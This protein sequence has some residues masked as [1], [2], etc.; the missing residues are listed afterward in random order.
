MIGEGST[1]GSSE[2]Q[3]ELPDDAQ[4]LIAKL[5]SVLGNDKFKY[6]DV[7]NK[8]TSASTEDDIKN[9]LSVEDEDGSSVGSNLLNHLYDLELFDEADTLLDYINKIGC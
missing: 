9:I 7:V 2:Q 4:A 6:K 8:L 5:Q 1:G 3:S